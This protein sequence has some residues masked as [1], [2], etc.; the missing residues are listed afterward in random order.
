[1]FTLLRKTL[2]LVMAGVIMVLAGCVNFSA[3]DKPITQP[4]SHSPAAIE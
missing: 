2:R 4:T 3:I 1:M